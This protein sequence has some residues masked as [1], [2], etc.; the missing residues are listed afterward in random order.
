M[1][2][3][4]SLEDLDPNTEY[5]AVILVRGADGSVARSLAYIFETASDSE[6]PVISNIETRSAIVEGQQ[7]IVQTIVTWTTNEPATGQVQYNEGISESEEYGFATDET[8]DPTT[9]HVIVLP[10]L[11]PSTVYQYRVRSVDRGDNETTS[12][13]RI[14]LTP[15]RRVSAFDLIIRNLEDTFGWA[16]NLG[17]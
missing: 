16:R 5:S 12:E 1:E 14:L 11:Q 2:H 3:R 13:S 17:L 15:Q 9:R 7:D 6:A 10:E 8:P 4:I